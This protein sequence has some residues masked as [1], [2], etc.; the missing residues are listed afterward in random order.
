MTYKGLIQL[1]KE[2][3]YS[4]AQLLKGFLSADQVGKR[5]IRACLEITADGHSIQ[6]NGGE[7]LS[8]EYAI[9]DV[10]E[11]FTIPWKIQAHGVIMARGT[12][13]ETPY[14]IIVLNNRVK[15][16]RDGKIKTVF[17]LEATKNKPRG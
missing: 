4:Q 10:L 1:S 13:T 17:P 14:D 16:Y 12:K 5:Y 15:I 6:W 7:I 11:M 3:T 9:A 2:L 8:L